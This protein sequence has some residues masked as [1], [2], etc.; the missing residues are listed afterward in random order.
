M[1]KKQK[2]PAVVAEL[3]RPE[4]AAETAARKAENSR[5]YKERKTVNNLVFSLLVSLALVAV[6]VL[7]VPRGTDQWSGQTVDVQA[8]AEQSEPTA[9]APLIAP[10]MPESWKA[11]RATVHADQGSDV[12]AWRIDYTTENE[13][14]AAA[15]QAYTSNGEPVDERW[16]AEQ[17]ESQSATGTERIGGLE[18]TVYDHPERSADSANA[19]FGLEAHVGATVLLVYGTDTPE[20]LRTLAAQVAD[21]AQRLDLQNQKVAE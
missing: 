11:K 18:W 7:I 14:Y 19:V 4:T 10:E 16:I 3:G 1:A 12:L 15:V 13:A 6:L 9:G 2:P 20:A 8:V 21:Q 5:L 17:L